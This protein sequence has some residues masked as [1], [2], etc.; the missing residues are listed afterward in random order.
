MKRYPP[1][2]VVLWKHF[3][4][5]A[6]ALGIA[7]KVIANMKIVL[8]AEEVEHLG[9]YS[10]PAAIMSFNHAFTY[11][12]STATAA[13]RGGVHCGRFGGGISGVGGGFGGGG[14]GAR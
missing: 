4:I 2:S 7:D 10:H 3:I 8:T 9:I 1:E 5:Y 12:I 14:G 13:S 6:T 11:G